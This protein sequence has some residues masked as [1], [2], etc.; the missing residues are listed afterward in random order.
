MKKTENIAKQHQ[1]E[2]AG[3]CLA[4]GRVG[5]P[6]FL[7]RQAVIKTKSMQTNSVNPIYQELANYANTLNFKNS[8][9]EERLEHYSYVLRILRN[10][11]VY[12]MQ[13]QGDD[14]DSRI[15]QAYEC[16]DGA[17]RLKNAYELTN[18]EPRPL[19]KACKDA[20]HS[21]PASFINL[22]NY[23]TQAWVAFSSQ[24]WS[25]KTI[26]DYLKEQDSNVLSRFSKIDIKK[27]KDS[28]SEATG[29]RAVPFKDIFGC[30]YQDSANDNSKVM[31]FRFDEQDLNNFKSAHPFVSLKKQKQKFA[32]HTSL[33]YKGGKP[34]SCAV[35][36]EDTFGI[37]EE[38]NSQRVTNLHIFNEQ[39]LTKDEIDL[40]EETI[41]SIDDI[42]NLNKIYEQ[43]AKNML[44][45][46]NPELQ[47]R[48]KYYQPVMFKKRTILQLMEQY[49]FSIESAYDREIAKVKEEIERVKNSN[50]DTVGYNGIPKSTRML[51][52]IGKLSEDK[53][54]ALNDFDSCVDQDKVIKFNEKLES[55]YQEVINYHKE[56]SQDYFIYVRWLFGKPGMVSQFST[57]TPKNVNMNHFW[58][59]EFD[60]STETMQIM[61]IS[62]VTSIL[63]DST[64][65]EIKFEQDS[66]LWDELLSNP[67]S[68]YY[69]IDYNNPKGIDRDEKVYVDFT[70]QQFY[71]PKDLLE[72]ST[73]FATVYNAYQKEKEEEELKNKQKV[74]NEN[75]EKIDSEIKQTKQKIKELEEKK[76]K[77]PANDPKAREELRRAKKEY[78]NKIRQLN[79]ELESINQELSKISK[80]NQQTTLSAENSNTHLNRTA[81]KKQAVLAQDKL[82]L[83]IE[84]HWMR[85]NAFDQLAKLGALPVEIHVQI[86]PANI[87]KIQY[88]LTQMHQGFYNR[89]INHPHELEFLKSFDIEEQTSKTGTV[90]TKH[91]KFT[92]CFPDKESKAIFVAFINRSNGTLSPHSLKQFME[93]EYKSYFK[94]IHKQQKIVNKIN[95]IN[96]GIDTVKEKSNKAADKVKQKIGRIIPK[97]E[98]KITDLQ[99]K[100]DD[101]IRQIVKGKIETE[102]KLGINSFRVNLAVSAITGYLTLQSILDN[103]KEWDKAKEGDGELNQKTQ[104]VKDA[105][106][107]ALIGID[108]T[109]QYKNIKLDMQLNKAI[110][111]NADVTKIE[112]KLRLNG[113]IS[114]TVNRALAAITVLEA[115]GE[116]KSSFDMVNME[117]KTYFMARL[118]GSL[119]L[120]FGA[121]LLLCSNPFTLLFGF[122]AML[123]GTIAIM[124]SKKYDNFTPIQ[125]WLNRCCFG[126]QK[127]MEF[128]GYSAYLEDDYSAH[129]GFGLALNDYAVMTYNIQTFLRQKALNFAPP[130]IPTINSSHIN[131][132]HIY[133]YLD[134][135]KFASFNLKENLTIYI[136]FF[137]INFGK[138]ADYIDVKYQANLDKGIELVDVNDPYGVKGYKIILDKKDFFDKY[139]NATLQN[140]G[141]SPSI[142]S[143][144]II[145]PPEFV[146]IKTLPDGTKNVLTKI[147]NNNI[148]N[149]IY[150]KPRDQE[151]DGLTINIWSAGTMPGCYFQEY[152]IILQYNNREEIPLIISKKGKIN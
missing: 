129:S 49:R 130:T 28:P 90:K 23:Y 114:K 61:H 91:A 145:E 118:F 14:I 144:Y 137:L 54:Q 78:E 35:V 89:G 94:L 9:P 50:N 40:A 82:H 92:L 149:M 30:S 86:R 88:L 121:V 102:I 53:T 38:L 3:K 21:I 7:L 12:V 150:E 139:D 51:T 16:I 125:H 6:V 101:I 97:F 124:F 127:E 64:H 42:D 25:S 136:R 103:L 20:D 19:S 68:I 107:L 122:I 152:Q 87:A 134:I 36:L 98:E 55:A 147:T 131:Q 22:N 1:N 80:A 44:K 106:S 105:V 59:R 32:V 110:N 84:S 8:M 56:W 18:T 93:Q 47:R 67:E 33:L 141:R 132:R 31:E 10:G 120:G 24:P 52:K 57:T 65:S 104:L 146:L 73:N 151:I 85:L 79:K 109:S 112:A 128:L 43:R 74:L 15:I 99:K 39:P 108:L 135:P 48:F 81:L 83:P 45:T 71:T 119:A 69:I 13:Q 140:S 29:K 58:Q 4:C 46:I 100:S 26:D 116:L 11:Y 75:K 142:G 72:K 126:I 123:I 41:N 138:A 77:I 62:E 113:L 60:F 70:D 133:F 2:A 111:V 34:I 27:L 37:A 143:V 117:D 66:A 148:A 96:E 5:I 95:K 76:Q 115:I 17:L 63:L